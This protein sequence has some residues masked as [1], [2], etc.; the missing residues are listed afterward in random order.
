M[1]RENFDQYKIEQYFT[2]TCEAIYNLLESQFELEHQHEETVAIAN[3]ETSA[4]A[5][6]DESDMDELDNYLFETVDQIHG[7]QEKVAYI[8]EER[9]KT[10]KA[11]FKE[12]VKNQMH[13]YRLEC[14]RLNVAEYLSIHGNDSYVKFRKENK[15]LNEKRLAKRDVMHV[16]PFFDVTDWWARRWRQYKDIAIM[17]SI[18]LGKPTHNAF[19]ERVFSRGTYSDTKLR[20]RRTE[21]S[22]EMGVVNSVNRNEVTK[23]M[24]LVD[25]IPQQT[26]YTYDKLFLEHH[27]NLKFYLK[28]RETEVPVI[29][30]NENE[31]ANGKCSDESVSS[32][33]TEDDL[34][35]DDESISVRTIKENNKNDAADAASQVTESS[36]GKSNKNDA[37]DASS[38]LTESSTRKSSS[39]NDK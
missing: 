15:V 37:M 36:T 6:T 22:F 21:E 27:S 10:K 28:M 30:G 29:L 5:E 25:K 32:T 1:D 14:D 35:L 26:D 24:E 34:D 38:Q 4:N 8:E 12:T 20:K 39:S 13:D 31:S 17:A 16:M 3:T 19:Q 7:E 18:M 33:I 23:L 9:V 11:A 2:D